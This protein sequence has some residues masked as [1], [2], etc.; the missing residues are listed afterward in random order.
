MSKIERLKPLPIYGVRLITKFV[1]GK[2]TTVQETIQIAE[3]CPSNE[4]LMNKINEI[5]DYINE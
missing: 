4:E 1:D 5:I 2:F 3:R